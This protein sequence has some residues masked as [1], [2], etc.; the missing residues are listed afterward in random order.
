MAEAYEAKGRSLP[1]PF[2]SLIPDEQPL[3]NLAGL[4]LEIVFMDI[5]LIVSYHITL[6]LLSPNVLLLFQALQIILQPQIALPY[7]PE[8]PHCIP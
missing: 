3:N 8:N 6:H 1:H 7:Y 5:H 2:H 4:P